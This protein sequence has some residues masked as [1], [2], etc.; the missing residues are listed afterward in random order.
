MEAPADD[1][2]QFGFGAAAFAMRSVLPP[3]DQRRVGL[4]SHRFSNAPLLLGCV[5]G[6]SAKLD[7]ASA[8][9]V[10]LHGDSADAL[11]VS[12]ALPV[13]PGLIA[14]VTM[15]HVSPEWPFMLRL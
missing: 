4:G 11:A 13:M 9:V 15:A 5:L 1:F 12:L 7:G 14:V 3:L 10:S 2:A 6:T 8:M